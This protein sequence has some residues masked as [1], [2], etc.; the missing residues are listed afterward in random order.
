MGGLL[1]AR[2]S[3]WVVALGAE[4]SGLFAFSDTGGFPPSPISSG[5]TISTV[6]AVS[7]GAAIGAGADS[8]LSPQKRAC[9]SAETVIAVRTENRVRFQKSAK[10]IHIKLAA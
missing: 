7:G 8:A 4:A 5:E 3:D 1:L 6:I 2:A 10:P 9:A